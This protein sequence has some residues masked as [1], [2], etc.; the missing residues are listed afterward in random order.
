ML[1]HPAIPKAKAEV[2]KPTEEG[3]VGPYNQYPAEGLP[4]FLI[5][6]GSH[7][8]ADEDIWYCKQCGEE[9]AKF[10]KDVLKI[11][12]STWA[13]DGAC[14]QTPHLELAVLCRWGSVC[15]C[16]MDCY[17]Y[18]IFFLFICVLTYSFYFF[19]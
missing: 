3:A 5:A 4:V 11:G 18:F 12:S 15:W 10:L 9:V 16:V 8:K 7:E 13:L 17:Y 14:L 1:A 19:T 2:R 6:H